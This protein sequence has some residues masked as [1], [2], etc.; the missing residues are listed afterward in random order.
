MWK[1]D[2]W[3]VRPSGLMGSDAFSFLCA[4]GPDVVYAWSADPAESLKNLMLVRTANPSDT[5]P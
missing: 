5:R 4:R 3:E 1:E 2:G